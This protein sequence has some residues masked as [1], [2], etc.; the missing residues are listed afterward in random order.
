MSTITIPEGYTP[1]LN[2]KETQIAIKK[3]KDFFQR[4]L[5]AQLNL[6][7]VS[8]PLFV[9]P[10][11]GLNDNLNGVERPVSFGVKEQNDAP[12]EVVHS[13]AKWKRLALKRYGFNVGEGL[14]TDM[15]AIR[16]DEDTD[17]IHSLYVDQWD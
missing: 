6:K 9:S 13:L 1:A 11:S 5:S 12:F 3:V 15:N 10:D 7:R 17:N 16:R 4:E 8:A 2:L 14:F